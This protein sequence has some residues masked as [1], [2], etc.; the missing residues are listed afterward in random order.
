MPII[1]EEKKYDAWKQKSVKV[2]KDMLSFY[3]MKKEIEVFVLGL[4]VI[5]FNYIILFVDH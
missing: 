3:V 4:M 2:K 1:M 5:I